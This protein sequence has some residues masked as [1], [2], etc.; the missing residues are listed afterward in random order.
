MKH[1]ELEE[2]LIKLAKDNEASLEELFNYY[3][4]RLYSFSKSFL[5][6]DEGIDDILQEV[7]VKIWQKRKSINSANTFNSYIFTITRNLLLNELRTRL[8]NENLKEEVKRLSLASEYSSV[9]QIEYSELRKKTNQLIEELPERQKEIFVLSR[10]EG[11][12]HK[13]IA[14]KL[15]ITTK[16]V[17]YHI[18]LAIRYIKENLKSYGVVAML[19]FYLFF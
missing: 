11:L 6:F 4:P 2:V 1:L 3:Y 15:G 18:S 13:E 12:T 19:Y 5:K 10:T 7:F 16:T 8:N 9:D 17:E 14:E